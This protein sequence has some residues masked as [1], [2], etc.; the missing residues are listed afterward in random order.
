MESSLFASSYRSRSF[1]LVTPSYRLNRNQ[2]SH[3]KT[4]KPKSPYLTTLFSDISL[5]PQ[6]PFPRI[7]NSHSQS[8]C[9]QVFSRSVV[10]PGERTSVT[11]YHC[12]ITTLILFGLWS[13]KSARS[14]SSSSSRLVLGNPPGIVSFSRLSA[15]LYSLFS[16]A[17]SR[18]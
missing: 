18:T 7:P 9:S 4:Q 2:E 11:R 15:C 5:S 6:D 13:V 12:A 17:R 16:Q 3:R 14:G 8:L 10:H 1:H